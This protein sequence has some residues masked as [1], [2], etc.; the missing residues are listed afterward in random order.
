ML[1]ALVVEARVEHVVEDERGA[2]RRLDAHVEAREG[3]PAAHQLPDT[4]QL[5]VVG[6]ERLR[7]GDPVRI[8][9]P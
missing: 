4:T 1:G 5:V 3:R 9:T 6:I 7:D 8:K 2:R